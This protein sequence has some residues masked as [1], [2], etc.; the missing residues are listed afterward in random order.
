M[1]APERQDLDDDEKDDS[2]QPDPLRRAFH[3]VMLLRA[4]RTT[5]LTDAMAPAG[6]FIA[7][8]PEPGWP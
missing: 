5:D 7:G 2:G 4:Q 3:D 6:R 8:R 1:V